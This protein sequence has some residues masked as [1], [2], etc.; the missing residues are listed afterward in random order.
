MAGDRARS[1][2]VDDRGPPLRPRGLCLGPRVHSARTAAV[3]VPARG[4]LAAPRSV[5]PVVRRMPSRRR[6]SSR[7][8]LA[9]RSMS[10]KARA[11]L[12]GSS[13]DDPPAAAGLQNDHAHPMGDDIM[14]LSRDPGPL[15]VRDVPGPG[16]GQVPLV[17]HLPRPSRAAGLATAAPD[18]STTAPKM[19]RVTDSPTGSSV[20]G[21]TLSSTPSANE[22]TAGPRG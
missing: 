8:S 20:S 16:V 15:G 21:D 6:I 4:S 14:Q 18:T 2:P 19:T 10:S 1:V 11:A 9:T 12:M 17:A 13:L 3:G 7:Q 22:T 5:G